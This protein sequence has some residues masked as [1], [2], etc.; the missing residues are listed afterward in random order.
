MILRG[1]PR[2]AVPRRRT[3][4][5]LTHISDVPDRRHESQAGF[6]EPLIKIV[7]DRGAGGRARTDTPHRN[8]ILSPAR[9]PIPPHPHRR[10]PHCS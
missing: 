2:V 9:L 3:T 5:H 10:E 8:W 4:E 1:K 7:E 6:G